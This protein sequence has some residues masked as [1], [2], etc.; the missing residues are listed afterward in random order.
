MGAG[1]GNAFGG[2]PCPGAR[3]LVGFPLS[4]SM[5]EKWVDDRDRRSVRRPSRLIRRATRAALC[6]ARAARARMGR[7]AEYNV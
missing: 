3:G 1:Q 2:W 6:D 7:R 4:V 5:T